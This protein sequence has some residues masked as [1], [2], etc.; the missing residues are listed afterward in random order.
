MNNI[1][2]VSGTLEKTENVINVNR[3]NYCTREGTGVGDVQVLEGM[4]L[5]ELGAADWV[6]SEGDAWTP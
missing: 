1:K 6:K 4:S 5:E 2:R 3:E